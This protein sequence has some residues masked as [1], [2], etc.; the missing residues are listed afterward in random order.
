MNFSLVPQEKVLK[1]PTDPCSLTGSYIYSRL[2]DGAGLQYAIIAARM[3]TNGT[4][5]YFTGTDFTGST[6]LLE[7]MQAKPMKGIDI[8]T[9]PANL[10][11]IYHVI[12]Y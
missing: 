11:P 10:A 1:I 6:H 7:I 8:T 9:L 4:V 5:T 2:I 12:L 3:E